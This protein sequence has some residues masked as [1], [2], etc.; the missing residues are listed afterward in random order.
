MAQVLKDD[1]KENILKAATAK[2][3]EI[4]YI[5]TKM[6]DIAV[7]SNVSV[8]NIYRYFKD[9]ENLFESIVQPVVNQINSIFDSFDKEQGIDSTNKA[10]KEF[11]KIYIENKEIFMLVIENSSNTKFDSIKNA[12][13]EKFHDN[14]LKFPVILAK[15][16]KDQGFKVFTRAFSYAFING[17]IS[18]LR[19]KIDDS[20]KIFHIDKFLSFMRNNMINEYIKG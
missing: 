11:I 10:A 17:I 5:N 15:V 19:E 2:F 4:G 16:K 18:I 7:K 13:I 9:K 20:Q 1:V 12:L 14:L 8:G 6:R 3:N